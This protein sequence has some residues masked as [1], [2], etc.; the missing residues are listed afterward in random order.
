MLVG[1]AQSI[2]TCGAASTHL[3]G[4]VLYSAFIWCL[5]DHLPVFLFTD[6]CMSERALSIGLSVTV[7]SR[8]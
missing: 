5:N 6:W 4:V 3:D 7:R 1:W 8:R 2:V